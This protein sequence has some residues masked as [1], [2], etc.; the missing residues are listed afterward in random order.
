MKSLTRH[1]HADNFELSVNVSLSSCIQ[2]EM[3]QLTCYSNSTTVHWK[4]RDKNTSTISGPKEGFISR[5]EGAN[6]LS[7][8]TLVIDTSLYSTRLGI[9]SIQ[10]LAYKETMIARKFICVQFNGGCMDEVSCDD[11]DAPIDGKISTY[12]CVIIII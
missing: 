10:C 5:M 1:L 4:V 12:P 6:G 2:G 3:T 8:S 11:H 9:W 7:Y